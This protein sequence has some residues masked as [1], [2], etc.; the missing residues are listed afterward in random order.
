MVRVWQD[1][2]PCIQFSADASRGDGLRGWC[3]L[4]EAEAR[5]SRYKKRK[6]AA[7]ATLAARRRCPIALLATHSPAASQHNKAPPIRSA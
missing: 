6:A 7:L 4:C 3:K 5:S 1:S 2:K